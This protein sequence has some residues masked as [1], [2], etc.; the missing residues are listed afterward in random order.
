MQ[1]FY[2]GQVF[3]YSMRSIQHYSQPRVITRAINWRYQVSKQIYS[4]APLPVLRDRQP[5]AINWRF[6]TAVE[7]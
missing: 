1:L 4:S 5:L 2:H 6:R 7:G 3:E